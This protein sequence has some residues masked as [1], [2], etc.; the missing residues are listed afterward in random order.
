MVFFLNASV[1]SSLVIVAMALFMALP[2]HAQMQRALGVDATGFRQPV[3]AFAVTV[4][5]NWKPKGGI[6]WNVQDPCSTYGYEFSWAALSPDERYG[7][8]ILPSLRWTNTRMS[9]PRQCAVMQIG[10]ARDA[11]AAM[12]GRM[13]PKA[14]ML[15]YRQRPDYLEGSS[16]R[17]QQYDLGG[18]AWMK[19]HV[20]AGEALF[21]FADERGNPMRITVGL[22]L[23]AFETYMPGGGVMPDM[24][25]VVGETMPAWAAFAPDGELNMNMSEQMRKSIQINPAWMKEIQAHQRKINGDNRRTQNNIA[26]INRETNEFISRLSQEGHENRMAAMDQSSADWSDMMLERENWRDTDGSQINTPVGGD[27]LWR[28]DN[29][30]LVSTDDHNFNPLESTGQ[31]GVQLERWN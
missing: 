3:P 6:I 16:T 30:A 22:I 20:D 7:V 23:T 15:D 25:S 8:A 13:L 10:S 2:V 12:V 18:G 19:S 14:Q 5:Q 9:G 26:N 31:F 29:G 21:S 27:N 28:L 1:R 24:R 17:A 11:I 4:P